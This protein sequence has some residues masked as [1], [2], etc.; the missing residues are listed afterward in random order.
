MVAAK[1]QDALVLRVARQLEHKFV[2]DRA[3]KD[4]VQRLAITKL[5]P[6]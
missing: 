2:F 5:A 6:L 1:Y 3:S 4:I